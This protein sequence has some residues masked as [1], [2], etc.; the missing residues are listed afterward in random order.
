MKTTGR[1]RNGPKEES[2]VKQDGNREQEEC[3][4]D[5]ERL[6]HMEV[7]EEDRSIALERSDEVRAL[8]E[9]Y[10]GLKD[11]IPTGLA[12]GDKYRENRERILKILGGTEKDW[13]DYKWHLRNRIGKVDVLSRIL[14]LTDE[15]KSQI[16]RA[17]E[18]YRWTISPYYASLMDPED[19]KCPIRLQAVPSIEE[20]L[21]TSEVSDPMIIKYNS[22][23]PLI[24]RLYPDRVIINVTNACAMFCR[25][26]LRRKDIEFSDVTYPGEMLER[27]IDYVRQ[28]PEIRDVLLTGGDALALSDDK[29]DYI[30]TELDQIPH[31]EI[32]RIGSRMPCVVPQRITP[33]LCQM[34]EKHD[35]VYLSTQFNHPKEVTVEA[36]EAIDRLTRSG[37]IVR[38]QTVLLKG[39]NNDKHVMKKLMQELLRIKVVPYYIFNCKK[40]EGIRHFRPPI[41]EGIEIIEHM[42]GYTS[43][44]AVPTFIITAPEGR[45]KT[46]MYPQ[47]LLQPGVHGKALIRT[48]GGHVLEYDD[49]SEAENGVIW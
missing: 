5:E 48:W 31:V 28:N 1:D 19:N 26:C 22:P 27:A 47:Y 42:R 21:D 40:V 24:S 6:T 44:M 2:K 17:G 8:D 13:N 11:H 3:P 23:A 16:L 20:Y 7:S 43:G 32:K 33:E 30:L 45:G 35:P 12:L 4:D 18:M 34:L 15:E 41:A 9:E 25:H 38:D 39:V 46:P 36:K 14:N 10:F 49:E 37:V 29:L